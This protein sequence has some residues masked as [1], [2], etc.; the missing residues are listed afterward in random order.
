M[1]EL[2][3]IAVINAKL[4]NLYLSRGRGVTE[5]DNQ[6]IEKEIRRLEQKLSA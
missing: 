4:H 5:K 6:G 3:R 1:S 2:D